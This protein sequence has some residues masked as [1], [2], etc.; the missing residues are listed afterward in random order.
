MFV[1]QFM[2]NRISVS[3]IWG[4]AA[5]LLCSTLPS[6]G[7][8]CANGTLKLFCDSQSHESNGPKVTEVSKC[9]P[10][11]QAGKHSA[12]CG[13]PQPSGTRFSNQ[14]CTRVSNAQTTA[15]VP[16]ISKAKPNSALA[17]GGLPAELTPTFA[18]AAAAPKSHRQTG[19]PPDLVIELHCLLI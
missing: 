12:C 3:V 16:A 7:C 17:L 15:T 11:K 14:T 13:E 2:H 5:L 4:M 10:A 8:V 18:T 9:C 1:M 19:P 6:T